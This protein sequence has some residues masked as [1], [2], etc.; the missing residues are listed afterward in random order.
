MTEL[1]TQLEIQEKQAYLPVCSY[2]IDEFLYDWSEYKFGELRYQPPTQKDYDE[3]LRNKASNHYI[4]CPD[5]SRLI[6]K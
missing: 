4:G 2:S 1:S 5:V 3:W 6:I